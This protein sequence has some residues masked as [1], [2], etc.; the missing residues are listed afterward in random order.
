MFKEMNGHDLQF[1]FLDTFLPVY[2]GNNKLLKW[3]EHLRYQLWKQI[4]LPIYAWLKGTDILFC[5]DNFVPLIHLGYQTIPVFHDAFFFESPQDYGKFWLW[6]YKKTAI[7]AARRSSFVVT[8]TAYAKKQINHFTGLPNDKL[9][10]IHEGPKTLNDHEK[11][12]E[13]SQLLTSLLITPASYILHVGSMFKRKNIPALINAF[14]KIKSTGY[15][16]LKLLLAGPTPTSEKDNDYRLIL[17]SIARANLAEDVIITGYL[18]DHAL[19]V[20]YKNALIYVFPSLNEGFGIPILE[21]FRYDLPVIV[22]DNTCLVEV[23][24]NAVLS[25]DPFKPD[26]LPKKILMLLKDEP[27]RKS[28]ISKGQQRLLNF[29]WKKTADEL[30]TLFRT[31]SK[32]HI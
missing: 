4:I 13:E 21:A 22:A 11:S 15:P 7:P 18:P 8:P 26:D 14:H 31:A 27:L 25:F 23:G 30:I 24:G 3:V 10:V 20:I 19:S 12:V 2:I 9:I 28:L 5:T 16:G 1:Y 32:N 6:I 29:S 17:S